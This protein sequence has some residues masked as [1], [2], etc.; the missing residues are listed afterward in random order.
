[1]AS[2]EAVSSD[3]YPHDKRGSPSAD[4]VDGDGTQGPGWPSQRP[5][6]PPDKAAPSTLSRLSIR[7]VAGLPVTVVP[8]WGD[9]ATRPITASKTRR[10]ELAVARGT[11]PGGNAATSWPGRVP[12]ER[13]SEPSQLSGTTWVGPVGTG[14]E[15]L[16]ALF[17]AHLGAPILWQARGRLDGC[18]RP[19][20]LAGRGTPAYRP[21]PFVL[22]ESRGW[23][24]WPPLGAGC[25][26]ENISSRVWG[27]FWGAG[28][29]RRTP[30]GTERVLRALCPFSASAWLQR[31]PPGVPP[32]RPE[33]RLPSSPLAGP[34]V[35]PS[36]L[37]EAMLG[38]PLE[39]PGT[40]QALCEYL[41]NEQ[42][43]EKKK[44][45]ERTRRI[46]CPPS[47]GAA[48]TARLEPR[49]PPF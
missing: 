32:G 2:E 48:E 37:P 3:G 33:P 22:S 46:R 47:C 11:S 43:S 45:G 24:R 19:S 39:K 15:V 30:E 17:R 9:V 5:I 29:D 49:E 14:S 35:H 23:Q 41:P 21:Q 44:F 20:H 42:E 31:S 16:S 38:P 34:A 10:G 40:R 6:A 26:T 7:R 8:L 28:A 1:M 12:H 13:L 27:P 18:C 4:R 25:R 36:L